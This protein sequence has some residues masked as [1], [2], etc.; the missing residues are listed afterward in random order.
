MTPSTF[1]AVVN[2]AVPVTDQDRTKALLERLGLATRMDAELQ[3]GF[4][5]IEM[6]LPGGTA[7]LA[8]VRASAELPA[9]I[10]TGIRLATTDAR[11]AHA[12]LAGLGLTVGALLDWD[13]VPLMFAFQD[14]DGNRFYVMQMDS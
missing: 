5:W 2:I 9:G 13:S 7:A 10:D 3:P 12:T 4:R 14:P 1:T 6:S 8:L 11:A